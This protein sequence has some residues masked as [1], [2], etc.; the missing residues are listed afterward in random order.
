MFRFR[1]RAIGL[2]DDLATGGPPA[3]Q[4]RR[5]GSA[6][7]RM[8]ALVGKRQCV[9]A[10]PTVHVPHAFHTS[11]F[12]IFTTHNTQH[13]K[14][15]KVTCHEFPGSVPGSLGAVCSR[16]VVLIVSRHWPFL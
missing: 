6:E 11:S 9:S 12:T 1:P 16:H 4:C 13:T 15:S 14:M 2:R 3:P 5:G 7:V 10:T 8:C